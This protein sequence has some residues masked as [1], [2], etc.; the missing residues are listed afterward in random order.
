MPGPKPDKM[1]AIL[2]E[3]CGLVPER[4][5][6]YRRE[7]VEAL[8]DIVHAERDHLIRSTDIQKQ[9]TAYCERLGDFLGG[10]ESGKG[11]P[12]SRKRK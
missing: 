6:G 4:R 9:V 12:E 1:L 5:D 3:Q 11:S 7:L 2:R 10:A 8:A